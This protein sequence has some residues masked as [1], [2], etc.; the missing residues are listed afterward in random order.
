MYC[1]FRKFIDEFFGLRGKWI[2]QYVSKWIF[3]DSTPI[4]VENGTI[5]KYTYEK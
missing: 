1:L 4:K 5:H 2:S 3:D